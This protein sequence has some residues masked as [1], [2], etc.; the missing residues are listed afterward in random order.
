[1]TCRRNPTRLDRLVHEHTDKRRNRP[2]DTG[3]PESALAGLPDWGRDLHMSL[4]LDER[5]ALAETG[6]W[7]VH[8]EQ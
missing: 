7:P 3:T 1:M 8:R 5:A 6:I 2:E 4:G